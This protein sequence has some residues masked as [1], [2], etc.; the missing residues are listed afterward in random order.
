GTISYSKRMKTINE[1]KKLPRKQIEHMKEKGWIIIVIDEFSETDIDSLLKVENSIQR[2]TFGK[3]Y[4]A[5]RTILHL[6]SIG[7]LQAWFYGK[8][9]PY[10]TL[11]HEIGHSVLHIDSLIEILS[12]EIKILQEK[13]PAR[14][15]LQD[16]DLDFDEL[17]ASFFGGFLEHYDPK[18]PLENQEI[19][20]TY[21]GLPSKST[22][23]INKVLKSIYDKMQGRQNNQAL[24]PGKGPVKPATP[25]E[26]SPRH[27][28]W[29]N[30]DN[31]IVSDPLFD[32]AHGFRSAAGYK[33]RIF[34]ESKKY[35]PYKLDNK[36]RVIS[37]EIESRPEYKA[38]YDFMAKEM[39]SGFPGAVELFEETAAT[40]FS[41]IRRVGPD[42]KL[43]DSVEVIEKELLEGPGSRGMEFLERYFS[44]YPDVS[45]RGR[46]IKNL[47]IATHRF[48]RKDMR[49]IEQV[50]QI[51]LE[52]HIY[53]S[54]RNPYIYYCACKNLILKDKNEVPEPRLE[55]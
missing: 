24:P 55:L 43:E 40:L 35:N 48:A 3:C 5:I 6:S 28:A 44:Q 12:G 37:K 22:L 11:F 51:A 19:I 29:K 46:F 2:F 1:L 31:E 42:Y 27:R 10:H 17:F 33:K 7:G 47:A 9:N 30:P 20:I 32:G 15:A 16:D 53:F 39:L 21:S 4:S 34:P 13:L 50:Y 25:E 45:R 26:S 49:Y 36:D 38:R 41:F 14:I 8:D 54:R 52:P 23:E 18:L